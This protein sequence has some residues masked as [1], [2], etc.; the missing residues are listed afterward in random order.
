MKTI[1]EESE[2]ERYLE[3]AISDFEIEELLEGDLLSR[4]VAVGNSVINVSLRKISRRE[5]NASGKG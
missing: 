4:P 2:K 1:Y 5:E 3:I